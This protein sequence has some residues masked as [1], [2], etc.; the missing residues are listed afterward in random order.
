VY[1]TLC[2]A[3]NDLAKVIEVAGEPVNRMTHN[4]VA[5]A[6]VLQK[7]LQLG[8]VH[9]L[10]RSL[11]GDSLLDGKSVELAKLLLVRGTHAEVAYYLAVACPIFCTSWIVS[12][13]Q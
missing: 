6:H 9:V 1:S 12:L 2:Q 11:I 13:A 10:S 3:Q 8:P 5:V 4:R 7:Q